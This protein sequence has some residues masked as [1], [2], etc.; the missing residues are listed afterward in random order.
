MVRRSDDAP[1]VAALLSMSAIVV[2]IWARAILIGITRGKLLFGT[3]DVKPHAERAERV[4]WMRVLARALPKGYN[5]FCLMLFCHLQPIY[6]V[7][8]TAN[9]QGHKVQLSINVSLV[10]G[11]ENNPCEFQYS[12]NSALSDAGERIVLRLDSGIQVIMTNPLI[13][14]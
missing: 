12:V 8:R 11:V 1:A 6:Q 9:L 13:A 4:G 2:L 3:N 7:I 10:D 5:L 14:V